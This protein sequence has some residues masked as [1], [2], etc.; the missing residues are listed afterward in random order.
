M[1]ELKDKKEEGKDS[2]NSKINTWMEN[3]YQDVMDTSLLKNS[4]VNKKKQ[5]F[6]HTEN[7]LKGISNLTKDEDLLICNGP[8]QKNKNCHNVPSTNEE[9]LSNYYFYPQQFK[10]TEQ[11]PLPD[12]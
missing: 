11:D 3:P 1:K 10:K 6:A 9:H 5:F 7:N 12:F 8:S 4:S 2:K